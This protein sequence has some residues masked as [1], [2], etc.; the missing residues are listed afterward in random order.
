M[1]IEFFNL[2]KIKLWS[3]NW[4]QSFRPNNIGIKFYNFEIF[5]AITWIF[6]IVSNV[7]INVSNSLDNGCKCFSFFV[8]SLSFGNDVMI[9]IRYVLKRVICVKFCNFE[10]F[11]AAKR[12]LVMVSTSLVK[13]YNAL[14]HFVKFSNFL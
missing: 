11:L 13:M 5:L 4:Y 1:F 6:V 14:I 2:H 10:I 8:F 12:I 3:I 7:W 9:L